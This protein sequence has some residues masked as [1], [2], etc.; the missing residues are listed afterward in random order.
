MTV[1][2]DESKADL[3]RSSAESTTRRHLEDQRDHL[4]RSLDQ[5]DQEL[6]AGDLDADDHREL[7]EAYTARL[8]SILRRIEGEDQAGVDADDS[9]LLGWRQ[10]FVIGA[11]VVFA[12]GAGFL[13]AQASGERGVG[14]SLTGAIDG[15]SRAQV[16]RCQELGSIDGDLVG[17]LECFDDVLAED[18]ENAE[19][20]SYRGWYLFLAAGALQ[21]QATTDEE[22]DQAD[23]LR[24]SALIYFDR[25][26]EADPRLPDPL[27]FRATLHDQEGASELA[28]RDVAALLELDPPSVFI[29]R[30][31]PIVDRN[32][33]PTS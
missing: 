3:T 15:S 20:L 30:T 29:E 27:A 11:L 22:R 17:A 8:A 1:A 9:A 24:A 10:V 2:G 32:D 21:D 33:C 6:A 19:A 23:E 4:L 5:L 13:L 14:D 28:C 31:D 12:I 16:T 26:I 25:A 18:P 7:T